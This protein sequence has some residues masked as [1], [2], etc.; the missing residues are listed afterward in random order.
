MPRIEHIALWTRDIGRLQDFYVKYFGARAGAGYRNDARDFDSCFLEFDG[1]ARLELMRSGR[2]DLVDAAAGAQRRGLT[3]IAIAVGSGA[4]VDALTQR[5][6]ADGY[7][8]LDGPRRTGDCY[9][10]SVV[11]DP[12]GNR[13]EVTA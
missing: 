1:G 6:A 8:V 2:V 4:A 9:Y 10:E 5:L 13:V 11:L 12:D 7:P 3:H